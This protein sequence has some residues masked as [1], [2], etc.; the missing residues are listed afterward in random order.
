LYVKER[1]A[2]ARAAYLLPRGQIERSAVGL[3]ELCRHPDQLVA[4][5]RNA[6]SAADS[7]SAENWYRRRA[8][9]TIDA[10]ERHQRAL[11]S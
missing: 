9:W 4:L 11:M 10:V 3:V 7:H 1:S 6:R 8:E 5:S 2:P